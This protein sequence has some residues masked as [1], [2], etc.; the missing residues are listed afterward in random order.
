MGCIVSKGKISQETTLLKPLRIKN[1][2]I[3]CTFIKKI[4]SFEQT[5]GKGSYGVVRMG[6]L[7]FD[8]SKKFAIKILDKA[9]IIE[10]PY[11]LEREIAILL[12]LDHPNII[13]FIEAYQD[14]KYF[15][16]VMEYCSGGELLDHIVKKRHL[17]EKE[18]MV[19]MQKIFSA[20]NY[21]HNKKIVHR[22][23][24]PENILFTDSSSSAEPK[25]IDFGLGN[26]KEGFSNNNT[27]QTKVGTPLYVAPEVL[28]E[29][30]TTKCDIWALGIIMYLLLSGNH[31][32]V[33]KTEHELY[34]KIKKGKVNF[35]GEEWSTISIFAKKL[36]LKLL[37]VDPNKRYSAKQ[38]L[39]HPWFTKD[40]N[41]VEKD[42][43]HPIGR[44]VLNM[45]KN[46][47]KNSS[48]FKKE[49]LKVFVN[50]MNEKE[51]LEIKKAFQVLDSDNTGYLTASQLLQVM[52][53]NNVGTS[54]EEVR[55]IMKHMKYLEDSQEG[56][57]NYHDFLTATLDS[58]LYINEQK[59]WNLFKYFDVSN[60]NEINVENLK[61]ILTRRGRK[62]PKKEIEKI[63]EEANSENLKIINFERFCQI[64]KDDAE[65]LSD[66]EDESK[67]ASIAESE[68][69]KRF[70][71]KKVSFAETELVTKRNS[72]QN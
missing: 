51:I 33:C 5:L 45:L 38:A 71:S 40:L 29:N 64:M 30:Y 56:R 58:K 65:Y 47:K 59:L 3:S 68:S 17:K 32:F 6:C 39:Q 55:K 2:E 31:P 60:K 7:K 70:S 52:K 25:I 69:P 49:V 42:S 1:N 15:Y 21:F 35:D 37:E 67:K 53:E 18:T 57:I 13:N 26:Y 8:P 28:K 16:L 62:L 19:I 54:E 41:L 61:D 34:A 12:K 22:D 46:I 63:I 4:Y 66:I 10:K 27:F 50:Q 48:K 43:P 44:N 24:K 23:L 11:M 9:R 72:A 14:F 36:I 20:V